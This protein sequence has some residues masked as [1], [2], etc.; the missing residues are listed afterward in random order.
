MPPILL[1]QPESSASP[2]KTNADFLNAFNA[3]LDLD[4]YEDAGD[5]EQL[6]D[7]QHNRNDT[8]HFNDT[9]ATSR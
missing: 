6:Q 1:A 8:D 9:H 5:A 2:P 7:N 3:Q 4:L